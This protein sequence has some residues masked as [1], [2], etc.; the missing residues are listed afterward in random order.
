MFVVVVHA[1][2]VSEGLRV[3]SRIIVAVRVGPGGLRSGFRD[4][5][6]PG[7]VNFNQIQG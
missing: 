3:M 7:I 1:D 5:I 6:Q 4:V 2:V